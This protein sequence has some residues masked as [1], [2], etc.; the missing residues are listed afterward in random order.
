LKA[1]VVPILIVA[2]FLVY[3]RPKDSTPP[4]IDPKAAAEWDYNEKIFA[5]AVY[6]NRQGDEFDRSC[7]FFS[8]LTG[9]KLHINYSTVGRLPTTETPRDLES[10]KAWYRVNK[11]RLY[12]DEAT[13][14]VKVHPVH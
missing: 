14:M 1:S 8:R 4:I 13:Y 7:E 6:E 3:C 9:I 12:W 11:G 2:L 5:K 10:I